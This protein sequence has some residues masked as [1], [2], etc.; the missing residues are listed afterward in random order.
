VAEPGIKLSRV[1]QIS[2]KF[3]WGNKITCNQQKNGPNRFIYH[4]S[5][6]RSTN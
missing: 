6:S 4:I 2:S 3:F 5:P 1:E